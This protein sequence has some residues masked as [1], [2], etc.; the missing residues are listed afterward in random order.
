MNAKTIIIESL[1]KRLEMAENELYSAITTHD[2][3]TKSDTY[4]KRNIRTAAT[5]AIGTIRDK[6]RAYDEVKKLL[7]EA[8]RVRVFDDGTVTL[9]GA[10]SNSEDQTLNNLRQRLETK[11]ST[12]MIHVYDKGGHDPVEEQEDCSVCRADEAETTFARNLLNDFMNLF[13]DF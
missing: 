3:Y 1:K 5:L 13:Y 9:G 8:S 12:N 11:A 7:D 6:L 10:S 4:S 2:Q